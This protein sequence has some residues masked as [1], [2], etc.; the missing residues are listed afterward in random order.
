MKQWPARIPVLIVGG[1]PSGLLSAA[2]L[3]RQ[4]VPSLLVERHS[5]TSTHPKA[6]G[7]TVRSMEIFRQCGLEDAMRKVA[8][9]TE[10]TRQFA[11]AS[12]LVDPGLNKMPF[13]IGD[14]DPIETSPTTGLICSQ[15]A[16]EAVLFDHVQSL[17]EVTLGF[18]SELTMLEPGTR[19]VT[20]TIAVDDNRTRQLEADYV[21]AA[22]GAQSGIRSSLGLDFRGEL[23]MHHNINVM[24]EAELGEKLRPLECVFVII[25]NDDTTG[26][27]SGIPTYRNDNEWTYNFQYFPERGVQLDD[28]GAERCTQHIRSAVGIEDLSIRVTNIAPWQSQGAVIDRFRVGRVLFV[29]DAA[30][31]VTPAGGLGM[32]TGLLDVHNLAWR[33]AAIFRGASERLLDDYASERHSEASL[34]VEAT[35]E[36]L[37]RAQTPSGIRTEGIRD[38]WSQPQHG[39][40]LGYSLS[41]DSVLA[42]GSALPEVEDPYLDYVPNARPGSRAPHLWLDEPATRSTLDLYDRNFVLCTGAAGVDW[43]QAA[44][45]VRAKAAVRLDAYDV[46][47]LTHAND[48]YRSWL[49]LYEIDESGAVLVRPDGTVA[50]RQAQANADARQN[51]ADV[52]YR[53]L[54][55]SELQSLKGQ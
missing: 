32:N 22:D 49:T 5:A 48:V 20:A 15:D 39:I 6:R 30:H 43:L 33:L 4:G 46:S 2:L 38:L 52:L 47:T 54:G 24:F 28:F 45:I 29:G 13:A 7:V 21:I 55:H 11:V 23:D 50:W 42:D 18:G 51:L 27:L 17:S 40:T 3:A 53:I 12:T 1:G 14:Q 26:V 44:D 36:N 16:L 8:P 37:R 25:K 10:H 34:I 31:V 9:A 35:V 19:G 41:S